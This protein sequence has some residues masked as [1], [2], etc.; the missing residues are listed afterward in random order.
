VYTDLVH[1]SAQEL[2]DFL[3][4]AL[5]IATKPNVLQTKN[6]FGYWQQG[7]ARTFS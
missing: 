2:N 3:F 5:N 7:Q 6:K 4:A 1:I